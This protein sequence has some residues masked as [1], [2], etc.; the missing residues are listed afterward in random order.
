M[1]RGQAYAE[2]LE[3]ECAEQKRGK[4]ER[5]DP[6]IEL[7]ERLQEAIA[8]KDEHLVH[9]IRQ[10]GARILCANSKLSK[11]HRKLTFI[12]SIF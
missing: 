10:A 8:L 1:H 2:L 4:N 7:R 5:R 6:K 12:Y 3:N 11:R 9:R